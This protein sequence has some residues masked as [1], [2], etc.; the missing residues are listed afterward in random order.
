MSQVVDN[1]ARNRFEMDVEGAIAFVD[2]RAMGDVLVVP[3][4]EV[5]RAL[6]GRGIGTKLVL[7]SLE[8]IRAS[9]RRVRP[10]CGF[11][12]NVIRRHPEYRDLIA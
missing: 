8:L 3:H 11:Y 12:A 7:G 10:L 9:G 5:P 2:Y 1:P 4:T 6:E